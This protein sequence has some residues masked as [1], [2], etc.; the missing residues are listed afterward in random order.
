M[1]SV[2][3]TG[4]RVD[5]WLRYSDRYPATCDTLSRAFGRAMWRESRAWSHRFRENRTVDEKRVDR[6]LARWSTGIGK[7]WR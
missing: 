1:S 6:I 4:R 5:R 7:E 3:R 2:R